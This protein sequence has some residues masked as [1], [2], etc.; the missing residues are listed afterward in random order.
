MKNN[1]TMVW[2]IVIVAVL[3][4]IFGGVGMGFGGYGGMMGMMY[5]TY[6]SGMM[7]FGWLYGVL[8]LV[9]LVLFIVWLARQIQ[10]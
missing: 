9:A 8:I 10:K 6:G 3:V 1:E 4:L 5:G 7:F 2:V